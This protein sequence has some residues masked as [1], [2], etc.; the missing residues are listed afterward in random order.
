MAVDKM[1]RKLTT[2]FCADVQSYSAL[3]ASD[4]AETLATAA[5]LS[6]DHERAVRAP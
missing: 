6:L 1:K 2:I 3:M 4:E 5:A